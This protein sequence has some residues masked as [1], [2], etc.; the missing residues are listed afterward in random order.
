A[1]PQQLNEDGCHDTSFFDHN[2]RI[3]MVLS[4]GY[5]SD[6]GKISLLVSEDGI[7]FQ[8][9]E[10]GLIEYNRSKNNNL[11]MTNTPSSGRFFKDPNPSVGPE[12]RFKFTGWIA[13][14]GIYLY[15]SPD[16]IHWRRNETCMLPLVSGGG[17]ETFWDDQ[18]G[19]YVTCLKHDSSFKPGK[20]RRASMAR[21]TE[22]LK[23]WPFKRL[24]G[25]YFE[26]WPFP[27]VTKELPVIF[28]TNKHGQVLRSRATKYEW[29]PDTYL[30]FVERIGDTRQ[31]DLAVSRDGAHW[32]CCGDIAWYLPSGGTFEGKPIFG[33]KMADGMVRRG[34]QIWQYA[35]YTLP[36]TSRL[37]TVRLIQRLDGFT[38]L[39]AGAKTGTITTRPLTFEGQRL[40]LNMAAAGYV[41]VGLLSRKGR[42][43]PGFS[44][45]DCD[46]IRADATALAVSW[47]GHTDLSKLAGEVVRLQFEMQNAKLYAFK[48]EGA[49]T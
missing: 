23:T 39:D 28:E 34:D 22:V 27:A 35:I 18:C 46:P 26:A 31:T 5:E 12:E 37:T 13:Q 20:G 44:T 8:K 42:P 32:K 25:P 19:C 15:L 38:S 41:R 43:I 6:E 24:G 21:T 14:R 33:A 49:G 47:K 4:D 2:G 11:I 16:A 10:L 30:A 9:P 1:D 3:Y 7:N 45:A 48:F 36:D 40:V 29:A 17:A